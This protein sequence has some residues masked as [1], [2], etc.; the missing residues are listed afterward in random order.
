MLGPLL[1]T[2]STGA[3]MR[4]LRCLRGRAQRAR[5]RAMGG[6]KKNAKAA[7]AREDVVRTLSRCAQRLAPWGRAPNPEGQSAV[8]M[9]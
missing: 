1:S 2:V 5:E 4:E 3:M 9:M 8:G 6:K 7:A